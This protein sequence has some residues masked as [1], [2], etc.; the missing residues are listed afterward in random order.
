M[1]DELYIPVSEVARIEHGGVE[2]TNVE[3]DWVRLNRAVP[4]APYPT[5]ISDYARLS[6]TER[7]DAEQYMD[8]LFTGEEYDVLRAYFAERG[9]ILGL[10]VVPIPMEVKPS[11]GGFMAT[12]THK[13]IA[14]DQLGRF[15]WYPLDDPDGGLP[16]QVV[17]TYVI[18][19]RADEEGLD[20]A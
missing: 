13:M 20:R 17:G 19:T 7:A 18:D 11:P 5:L 3:V 12:P 8:E 10:G 4:I 16:F 14:I 2:Y 1:I 15:G 6:D 9:I